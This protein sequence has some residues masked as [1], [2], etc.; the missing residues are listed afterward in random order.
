MD[1]SQLQG[2]VI[3]E[4]A[5]ASEALDAIANKGADMGRF[6]LKNGSDKLIRCGDF[7]E[8]IHVEGAKGAVKIIQMLEDGHRVLH[9]LTPDENG[10]CLL[11]PHGLLL[12]EILLKFTE[13]RIQVENSPDCTVE[14]THLFASDPLRFPF[15]S[16]KTMILDGVSAVS[17]RTMILDGVSA[18][19]E[20]GQFST[21]RVFIGEDDTEGHLV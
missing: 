4:G 10:K 18:V 20:I 7:F 21:Y 6:T 2:Y 13:V 11:S 14:T 15:L 16:E 8:S 17:E 5:N 19:S 9:V 12:S 1:V 3:K